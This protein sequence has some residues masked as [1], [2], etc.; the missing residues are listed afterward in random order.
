M[1]FSVVSK[2][3]LTILE[4]ELYLEE[5]KRLLPLDGVKLKRRKGL[6]LCL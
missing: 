6:C 3:K 4:K 5:K 1:L 2:A